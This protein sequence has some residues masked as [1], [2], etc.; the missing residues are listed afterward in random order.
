MSEEPFN[1]IDDRDGFVASRVTFYGA[2]Y[3]ELREAAR[4]HGYA[5]AV[6]GSL[7]KDL[8]VVAVPWTEDAADNV[9]LARAVCE[10]AGGFFTGGRDVGPH[11]RLRYTI[12]LGKTG[13]Y[14]D[15]SV[16]PRLV[17]PPAGAEVER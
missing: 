15:L 16:M 13:G 4:H 11:G 14:V 6:H 3:P 7:T 9:T 10:A 5:L 17:P 8:D 2:L 12:H 1:T